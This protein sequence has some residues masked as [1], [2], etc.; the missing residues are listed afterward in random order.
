MRKATYPGLGMQPLAGK[1]PE[2]LRERKQRGM[3]P[4]EFRCAV[5]GDRPAGAAGVPVRV[6]YPPQRVQ[7]LPQ[8]R[9]GEGRFE[10][11]RGFG[12]GEGDRRAHE[13]PWC[14]KRLMVRG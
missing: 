11:L 3:K 6:G 14:R 9:F 12:E 10:E 5:R 2:T 4:H 8:L 7:D 1:L 13:H